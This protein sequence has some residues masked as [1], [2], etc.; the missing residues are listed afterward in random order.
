[1]K[2]K[3]M[4]FLINNPILLGQHFRCKYLKVKPMEEWI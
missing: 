1:M 2:S 4:D 3:N